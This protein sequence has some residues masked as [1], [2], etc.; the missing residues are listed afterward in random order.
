MSG[1]ITFRK[2]IHSSRIG[3][4]EAPVSLS[5]SQ[6]GKLARLIKREVTENEKTDI[7]DM[8]EMIRG[9]HSDLPVSSQDAIATL[10]AIC[11]AGDPHKALA[12]CDEFTKSIMI[13]TLRKWDQ[14]N[15]WEFDQMRPEL[16]RGAAGDA[17]RKVQGRNGRPSKGYRIVFARSFAEIWL[18][19]TGRPIAPS[20]ADGVAS[21]DVEAAHL[22]LEATGDVVCLSVVAKLLRKVIA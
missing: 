9:L 11:G 16:L 5:A 4:W 6:L 13:D 7:E 2:G 21:P 17:C 8:L 14:A 15:P 20:E 10:K 1:K 18:A 3:G 22:L 12:H 19:L